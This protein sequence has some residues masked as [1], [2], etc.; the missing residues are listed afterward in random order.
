MTRFTTPVTIVT[1]FLGSGKTTLINRILKESHGSRIAVIENEYG[2]VGVDGEFLATGGDETIILLQNGCLCCSVRGDLARALQDLAGRGI[3]FD[4]VLIETTGI[5]DPGPVIQTFLAETRLQTLFHLDG[6][7][8]LVDGH[9]RMIADRPEIRAQ[10]GHADRLL[11][12]KGD[13]LTGDAAELTATLHGINP[14]APVMLVDLHRIPMAELFDLLFETR[15]YAPDYIPADELALLAAAP[16]APV[17]VH[18]VVSC[19]YRS[20]AAV[21]LDKLNQLFD[22]LQERFG[23]KLWRCKGVIYAQGHRQRLIVQ[24]VQGAVQISA[25]LVW[26]P[27]QPRGSTLV[28]IGQDFPPDWL[29]RG[30]RDCETASAKGS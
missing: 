1:G 8:T 23:A 17:H 6:T 12:T 21:D 22:A 18:D 29:L 14:R 7:I 20:Q 19:V 16:P 28:F 24:G 10:I 4:R 13:L 3:A 27:Y 5:A 9:H 15:A 30:L 25:G 26:R 2:E 11:I